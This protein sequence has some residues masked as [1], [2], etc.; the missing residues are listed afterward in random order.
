P[1]D[2]MYPIAVEIE[3][4]ISVSPIPCKKLLLG[5]ADGDG[6]A[7]VIDLGLMSDAWLA[8]AGIDPHFDPRVDLSFDGFVNVVDLG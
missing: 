2:P 4:M 5:D 3:F 7:N 8:T 1:Y 6:Y